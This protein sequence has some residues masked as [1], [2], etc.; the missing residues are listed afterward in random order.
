MYLPIEKA[1]MILRTLLQCNSLSSVS[2]LLDVDI[3]TIVR[4]LVKPGEKAERIMATKIRNL[5]VRDVECDELSAFIG[6]NPKKGKRI[7]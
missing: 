5:E 6:K 3:T 1:E 4:L 7:C 2:R